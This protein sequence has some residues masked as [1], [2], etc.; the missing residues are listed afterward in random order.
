M[1]W[2][3]N[4]TFN[5]TVFEKTPTNNETLKIDEILEEN[6]DF[7]I[8]KEF[9]VEP[10]VYIDK[11]VRIFS[12]LIFLFYFL[13]VLISKEQHKKNLIYVHHANL[14]G[15]LFCLMYLL[16]FKE[17]HPNFKSDDVNAVLCKL[18]ELSWALLKYLRAYSILII[19]LYRLIAVFWSNLFK[20]LNSSLFKLLIPIFVIWS[21]SLVL[22][23]STKT[24]FNTTSGTFYCIDGFSENFRDKL[25][26]LI[27][28]TT[29][30]IILP[31]SLIVIIYWMI[32]FELMKSQNRIFPGQHQQKMRSNSKRASNNIT[33]TST[34]STTNNSSF[35]FNNNDVHLKNRRLN[36]QLIAMNFC[37]LACFTVSS[38][39]SFRYIIPNF[40]KNFY[41]LRQ[42]LRVLNIFF[43]SLLPIISIYFNPNFSYKFKTFFNKK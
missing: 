13:L 3:F 26:Y 28:N 34:T 21:M 30:C 27:V 40:N 24:I 37:Y 7:F 4:E 43:Q 2:T 38:I 31:F 29:L 18:S 19:A 35:P 15:F 17:K 16:Y 42:T 5:S 20:R 33:I 10:L 32:R 9:L 11:I 23:L 8:D 12:I 25:S 1:N 6:N 36:K 41:Y 22:F 39:L 14:I